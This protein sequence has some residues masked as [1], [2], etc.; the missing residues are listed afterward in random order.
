MIVTS[1]VK[2]LNAEVTAPVVAMVF[3]V[4]LIPVPAVYVDPEP[5]LAI[6]IVP[7]PLVTVIPDPAV[8]VVRVKPVPFPI[9]ICPFVGV[10]VKPVPPL[11]MASVD[12]KP[13]AFPV[14]APVN[15][16]ELTEVKPV[17][18]VA[19]PPKD[20]GVDPIVIVLLVK[21]E[22]GILETYESALP[23]NLA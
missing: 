15:E 9:S 19:D 18:V 8:M 1:V 12:D 22:F 6:V 4:I 2:P 13:V 14:N 23:F 17:N 3:P 7:E 16:V 20:I 11:L 21:S 10:V 5:V